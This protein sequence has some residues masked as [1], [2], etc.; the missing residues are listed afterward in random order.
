MFTRTE[1]F[2]LS[3]G[4]SFEKLFTCKD[5][6]NDPIDISGQSGQSYMRRSTIAE[7]YIPFVFTLT[8]STGQ[9][10]LSLGATTSAGLTPGKYVYDVNLN[11]GGL[12]SRPFEGV[13]LVQAALTK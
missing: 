2:E 1:I 13:I 3:Q 12:I 10:T 7:S 6:Y 9:F 5:H 11:N 4:T 8:G